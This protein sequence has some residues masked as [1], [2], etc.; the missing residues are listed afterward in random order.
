MCLIRAGQQ[1]ERAIPLL[2][3]QRPRRELLGKLDGVDEALLRAERAKSP[4]FARRE[5]ENDEERVEDRG[6]GLEEVVVVTRQELAELVDERAEAGSAND[7]GDEARGGRE[8]K[9]EQ[10][11]RDEH[12]EA[13]PEDMRDVQT[14][15]TELRVAGRLEE[16]ADDHDGG[17]GGDEKGVEEIGIGR[18]NQMP[19]PDVHRA[20][21]GLEKSERP[22][23]GGLSTSMRRARG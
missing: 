6:G 11:D 10:D 13:A 1:L 21:V 22:P 3:A 16:D 12:P 17:D 4:D 20:I 15:A 7:R 19:R 2:R 5:E 8:I 14:A 18:A 9:E 23:F